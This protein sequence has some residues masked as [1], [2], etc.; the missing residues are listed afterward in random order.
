[1]FKIA[2]RTRSLVSWALGG[3]LMV[4]LLSNTA[5]AQMGHVLESMGPINQSMGGAATGLALDSMS[6]LHWN[7]ASITA[8]KSSEIGFAF[9]A[10]APETN[11]SSTLGPMS[12]ST[13]S[14]VDINP[15]PAF[16]FVYSP[17]DSPWSYG[18][19]GSAIAGFGVDYPASNLPSPANP[20]TN[21]ILTPQFGTGN[22][23][24]FGAVHS[25]FQQMQIHTTLACRVTDNWSIGVAPTFNW[26]SLTVSPWPAAAPNADGTYPSGGSADSRWGLGLQVGAYWEDVCSGWSF[27]AS[28]KTS[29]W[30]E[31]YKINSTD[32]SGYPRQLTFDMDYPAII[33]VGVGYAGFERLSL[34]WDVRYIDYN[35]TDGF[36]TTGFNPATGAIVGFGWNSIVTTSLGAQY[37]VSERLSVRAGYTFNENPIE[38]KVTF[39]N[40]HAPAIVQN[41][42]SCGFS[43]DMPHRWTLA[44]AYTY[45]FENQI[46]GQW[47][48]P[49]GPIPGSSVTSELSTHLASGAIYVKF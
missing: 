19:G 28:Y 4:L 27:G 36:R 47:Q 10:L 14:D 7:P 5:T 32:A 24:G 1:M 13:A 3:S 38:D 23:F 11:I 40:I 6:A 21:P 25:S 17:D 31:E 16:A 49:A 46:T 44:L 34:A 39:Y 30:V 26:T 2:T 48:S 8:L 45:G 20:T 9:T 35:N 12:G 43:Y 29:Q 33:S 18:I 37:Q 15:M 22:G 41:H 42:M